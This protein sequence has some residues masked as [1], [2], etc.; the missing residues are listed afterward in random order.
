VAVK[1]APRTRPPRARRL[2]VA[3]E[4]LAARRRRALTIARR[5]A[6]TYPDA[7]CALHYRNPWELLVATI[8]SAQCTD[9][10]VNQVTPALFGELPEP[11]ALAAAPAGRVE[12]LIKRTGF[13]RQKTKALQATARVIAEQHR[14]RV[15]ETME[16]LRALPGIGRKT[17]NVVL[18]TA[19]GQPA[20]FV[21]THVRRVANRLG[22]T[23]HDDPDK[24]ERDLQAL[25][26]PREWTAFC[27]RM[28]HHGRQICVARR[29]R[30]S[31]CPLRPSCPQIGVTAPA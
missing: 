10:M 5:L 29:P 12:E 16:A 21:D 8:L 14:G 24:I 23:V 22:L 2:N 1:R 6:R 25:L 27:H 9:A 28:I 11:A 19:F 4:S 15:P 3:R 18:G 17:A 30:C 7:W 20:V 13:F 26:P 31:V